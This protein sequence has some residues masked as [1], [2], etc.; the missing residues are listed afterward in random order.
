M[1]EMS[2]VLQVGY[3]ITERTL[4]VYMRQM[5]LRSIVCKTYNVSIGS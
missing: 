1:K 2:V 5:K 3:S 4:S